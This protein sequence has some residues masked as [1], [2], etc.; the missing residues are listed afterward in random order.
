MKDHQTSDQGTQPIE[1]FE[2]CA[3]YFADPSATTAELL[4][5]AG[6]IHSVL[7]VLDCSFGANT[8]GLGLAVH[9]VAARP[10]RGFR[11]PE[12]RYWGSE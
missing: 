2:I 3:K 12:A 8:R 11:R 1:V 9:L 4:Q 7:T 10:R 6:C 5:D